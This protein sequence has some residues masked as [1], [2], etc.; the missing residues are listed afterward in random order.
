MIH[1]AGPSRLSAIS[2][3]WGE[4]LICPGCGAPLQEGDAKLHC[5]QCRESWPIIDGVPHFIEDFP[6]W[7][8]IPVEQMREVTRAAQAGPWKAALLDSPDPSVQRAAGMILNLDRANWHLLANLSPESR[9]LDLGAGMGA[10]S[11]ALARHYREVVAVEP[12]RERVEFMQR[13]FAQEKL[14]NIKILRSSLWTLP[15]AEESF[16]LVAMNGLLE[17][18]AEGRAGDPGELQE[19]AVRKA[20]ALL[21]PGGCL[22]LGIEN[23]ICPGYFIGYPDPHCGLPF[24]TVLPRSLAQW[25]ARRKGAGVGYRNYLYSSRGYRK[26]LQKAGFSLVE[27]YLAVPSYNLPRFLIPLES[28]VFSYYSRN[29]KSTHSSRLRT[30]TRNFLLRLKLLKYFEYSFVILAH[31]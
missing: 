13:R 5:L 21:R 31:R 23:R 4:Q 2:Q 7:G 19:S 25:Y 6:Y 11:H 10:T 18:V 20:F 29:F 1:Q 3:K 9:I 15:F 14:S 17:L 16:D 26:L 22:Y 30:L 8:E 27:F 24:V 28:D 12:V